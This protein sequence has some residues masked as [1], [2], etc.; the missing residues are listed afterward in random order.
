VPRKALKDLWV[1][2]FLRAKALIHDLKDELHYDSLTPVAIEP[3][4]RKPG[5]CY[6]AADTATCNS[7]RRLDVRVSGGKALLD[8]ECRQGTRLVAADAMQA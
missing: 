6:G 5:G 1:L 4:V 2:G 7:H 3:A 8:R